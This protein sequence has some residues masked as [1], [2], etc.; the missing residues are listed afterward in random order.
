V[1]GLFTDRQKSLSVSG[2][3]QATLSQPAAAVFYKYEVGL[4]LAYYFDW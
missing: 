4:G 3:Y 2:W 1:A